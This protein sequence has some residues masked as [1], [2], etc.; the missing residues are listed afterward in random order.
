MRAAGNEIVI[1]DSEFIG[2]ANKAADE[3]ADEQA[4][5]NAWFKRVLEHRRIFQ[6]DMEKW[7]TFR[8]PIGRR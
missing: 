5:E 4:A 2:A 3:W 7:P 1:L 8:F 6:K